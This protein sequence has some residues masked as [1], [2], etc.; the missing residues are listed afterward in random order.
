ML[1]N[2]LTGQFYGLTL[3]YTLTTNRLQRGSTVKVRIYF[4]SF[5]SD[6]AFTSK[7]QLNLCRS[8][9]SNIWLK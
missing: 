5:S 1:S 8:N 4:L 9:P 7:T 3:E 6:K 2:P